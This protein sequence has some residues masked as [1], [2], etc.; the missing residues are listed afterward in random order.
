MLNIITWY[1][2][3]GLN[4]QF[5]D[6]KKE[7]LCSP[8]MIK[9]L[10]FKSGVLKAFLSLKRASFPIHTKKKTLRLHQYLNEE[11]L[12]SFEQ[13]QYSPLAIGMLWSVFSAFQFIYFIVFPIIQIMIRAGPIVFFYYFVYLLLFQCFHTNNTWQHPKTF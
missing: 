7:N 10:K 4:F 11:K 1:R 6:K 3:K 13:M 8:A 2:A 12:R 5:Q 9:S